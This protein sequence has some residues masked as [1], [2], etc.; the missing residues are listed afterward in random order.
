MGVKLC[1]SVYII[2]WATVPVYIYTGTV[3]HLSLKK[4]ISSVRYKNFIFT[5]FFSLLSLSTPTPV[6][7]Q[8]LSPSWVLP[9]IFTIWNFFSFSPSSKII[10]WDSVQDGVKANVPFPCDCING[11]FLVHMFE[12]T[13][14]SGNTYLTVAQKYY[15]NLTT[16]QLLRKYNSYDRNN[17]PDTNAKLNATVTCS[18]G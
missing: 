6:S 1:K 8:R 4:I 3:A 17:I 12:Y 2:S 15:A 9:L 11:E 7:G 14:H 18:W 10:V 16:Y 5:L 13:V